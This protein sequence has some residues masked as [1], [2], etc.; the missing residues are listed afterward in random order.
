MKSVSVTDG[1]SN[2][3]EAP[4]V[5]WTSN[6]TIYTQPDI[7]LVVDTNPNSSTYQTI[8]NQKLMPTLLY[9]IRLI[10]LMILIFLIYTHLRQGQT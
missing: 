8:H 9:L 5:T 2:I 6:N 7:E 10:I 4:T 3:V 1:G